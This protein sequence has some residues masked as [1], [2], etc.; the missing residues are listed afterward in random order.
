MNKSGENREQTLR[1][2]VR[3]FGPFETALQKQWKCFEQ[4]MRTGFELDAISLDLEP[5][6]RLLFE[7]Q[8][9]DRGECDLALVS[10][11]WLAEAN[12]SGGLMDL[13]PLLASAPPE[14]YPD[15]WSE[16]LLRL[17]SFD[18][19]V[20]GLPYHDGPECLIYR[21]DLF[22]CAAEQQRFLEQYREPLHVPR[23]WSEFRRVARFF[24]R[25]DEGLYGTVFAGYPDG[26]NTVY[27]FCLQLWSRGGQ[28]FDA[29]R[30]ILLDTAE[31][32]A[33]LEYYRSLCHDA[34]AI[35]PDY[36]SFDSVKSGLAFAAG[37]I[38]MMVNWFGFAAMSETID[39]SQVKGKT[40]IAAIPSDQGHGI[41]LN[42]YWI[43]GIVA[44]TPH[45]DVAWKF[46]C[47]CAS[48]EM[49]KLLTLEG[50]IGCRK[51]T[52]SDEQV[53]ASIPYYHRL[54][55]LHENARELPRISNWS[56]LAAVVDRMVLDVMQTNDPVA[57]ITKRAQ[58]QASKVQLEGV[59]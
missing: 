30:R 31:A 23:T 54:A 45:A 28:L 8:D 32:T 56:K 49:D 44:G 3:K 20:L 18:G 38:A 48:A 6:H 50:G 39:E 15:A 46:L 21:R 27:D 14:G 12:E 52:W 43:I 59:L 26:H 33:A 58:E 37:E 25:P 41:S 40:A 1:I 29:E 4:R 19:R 34:G 24:T 10:T 7:Q 16:S 51:S 42:A 36:A 57:H 2:A 47:H 13:S 17:Q 35:H 5:L 55:Q 9:L 53:N 22:D 11:D